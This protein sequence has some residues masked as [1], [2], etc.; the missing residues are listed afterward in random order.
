MNQSSSLP[1]C[2]S[3]IISLLHSLF[4]YF[5]LRCVKIGHSE[6]YEGWCG[7]AV[8][9]QCVLTYI[10]ALTL[11]GICYHMCVF[12][13]VCACACVVMRVLMCSY[14]H[15]HFCVCV[16]VCVHNTPLAA[17]STA[18]HLLLVGSLSPLLQFILFAPLCWMEQGRPSKSHKLGLMMHM[19]FCRNKSP[20][21]R[22]T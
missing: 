16:C 1:T 3:H 9:S 18:L 14:V 15:M 10:H 22:I 2:P 17:I 11:C 19:R 6:D 20:T 8:Q 12:V 7:V 13:C 4:G 21:Q 5:E